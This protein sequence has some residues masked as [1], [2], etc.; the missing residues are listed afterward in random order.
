MRSLAC[1]AVFVISIAVLVLAAM[2]YQG[3]QVSDIHE[4]LP[5]AEAIE[6]VAGLLQNDLGSS[7]QLARARREAE[8]LIARWNRIQ[9][10]SARQKDDLDKLNAFVADLRSAEG[11]V[12]LQK[13][14]LG[15]KATELKSRAALLKAHLGAV[16]PL[17]RLT[18]LTIKEV[19]L[20]LGWPIVV[21]VLVGY[22]LMAEGAPARVTQLLSPFR[23]LKIPGL[24]LVVNDQIKRSKP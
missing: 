19:L 24:E 14:R 23:S 13:V 10:I 20:G 21:V 15:I 7:E 8:D 22:L 16:T 12:D 5:T 3:S 6:T 18:G 1:L 9:P 2:I 11:D 17:D 4:L